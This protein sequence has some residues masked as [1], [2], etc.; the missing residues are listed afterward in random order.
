MKSFIKKYRLAIIGGIIGAAG[1]Y[2]YYYFIGCSTGSCAIT[3]K[4]INSTLYGSVM[5]TLLF[6][7]FRKNSKKE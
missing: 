2:A 5:G 4:P 1:G 7:S 3:S 6:S